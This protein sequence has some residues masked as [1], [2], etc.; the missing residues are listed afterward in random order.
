MEISNRQAEHRAYLTTPVWKAKRHEALA[1]YGCLCNRC[2]E[3]GTDVHH[4]TYER[5]GGRE[6][7]ED[8]EILCRE[9]HEAHHE[10][11]R[12]TGKHK[13]RSRRGIHRRAIYDA[14]TENHVKI[15][16]EEFPYID[17]LWLE[18]TYGD[19]E[20][21]ARA[22]GLL[23]CDYAHGAVSSGKSRIAS[24]N[25]E[26][27]E[28]RVG[29]GFAYDRNR[30]FWRKIESMKEIDKFLLTKHRKCDCSCA[31]ESNKGP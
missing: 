30:N 16:L 20:A 25:R 18:L 28:D 8:L 7:L 9:C 26:V 12:F 29:H 23:G 17:D 11:E 22:A 4:K 1:L 24:Q 19:T 5:V 14:L 15:L 2:G 31:L 21:A 10:C 6:L 13:E 3:Y 27:P